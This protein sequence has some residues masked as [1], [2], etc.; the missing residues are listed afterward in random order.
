MGTFDKSVT[1]NVH[2]YNVMVDTSDIE[3]FAYPLNDDNA[4]I[5]IFDVYGG[6]DVVRSEYLDNYT[7]TTQFSDYIKAQLE[8]QIREYSSSE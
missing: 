5:E 6:N 4:Y 2:K 1:G 8:I 7:V 3:L